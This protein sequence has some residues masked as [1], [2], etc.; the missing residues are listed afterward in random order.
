MKSTFRILFYVKRDR[1]K[2]NGKVPI[3]CRIT[4][5]KEPVRFNTKLEVS[6]DIWDSKEARVT[7][8]SKEA[9][10]V[11]D[12][13]EK[14]QATLRN[15]YRDLQDR[16]SYVTSEKVRNNFLGFSSKNE[17]LMQLF[18]EHNKEIEELVGISKSKATLQKYRVTC[19]HLKEFMKYQY[20][21]NDI[22]LKEIDHK[23]ITDFEVYLRTKCK[24]NGN[25]TG[26]FMNF[27]KK[28]ILR[29][30]NRGLIVSNPFANYKV[31]IKKVDRGLSYATGTRLIN[32]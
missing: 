12:M 24:C 7:G 18:E 9:I 8:K 11:N 10:E 6:P 1:Q 27:F 19:R 23:F 16:E 26:K 22:A 3:M 14:I 2:L 32:E 17:T 21:I 20:N 28:I 15:I 4:I 25:T 5:N 31:V 13:L 29:A 30:S